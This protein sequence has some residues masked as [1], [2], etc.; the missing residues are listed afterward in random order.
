M[1]N[2]TD[3]K[4]N[5]QQKEKSHNDDRKQITRKLKCIYCKEKHELDNC[6]KKLGTG[7]QIKNGLCLKKNYLCSCLKCGHVIK[8]CRKSISC[9]TCDRGLQDVIL[10]KV[11]GERRDDKFEELQIKVNLYQTG[12]ASLSL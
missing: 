6:K 3:A 10:E 9:A 12:L 2:A 7:Q 1:V 11:K 5:E 8:Y 4:E